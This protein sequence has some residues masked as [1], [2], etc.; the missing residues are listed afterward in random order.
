MTR[1]QNYLEYGDNVYARM[2]IGGKTIAEFQSAAMMD[3]SQVQREMRRLTRKFRGLASF[4]VRNLTRGWSLE[5]PMMLYP[6]RFSQLATSRRAAHRLPLR[7]TL[8]P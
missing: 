1:R 8:R 6:D 3:M 5:R 2:T 4:Y 7:L